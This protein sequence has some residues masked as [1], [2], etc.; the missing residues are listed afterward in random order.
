M[1]CAL[2]LVTGAS[3]HNSYDKCRREKRL[4]LILPL[5]HQL[6]TKL[7]RSQKA[8]AVPSGEGDVFT[9]CVRLQVDPI[10]PDCCIVYSESCLLF[11][12]TVSAF[13][14]T[15]KLVRI[16]IENTLGIEK[17]SWTEV[18][19]GE[20][21]PLQKQWPFDDSKSNC[22]KLKLIRQNLNIQRH[23][24]WNDLTQEE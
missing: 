7:Q 4:N 15:L 14:L 6:W 5:I 11:T 23:A 9:Q 18:S 21:E 17:K 20:K 12:V 13:P 16:E 19:N 1:V 2:P 3:G 8:E 24:A 10:R 22:C